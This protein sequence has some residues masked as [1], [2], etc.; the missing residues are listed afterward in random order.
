MICLRLLLFQI[1]IICNFS[2]FFFFLKK[3]WWRQ[4]CYK[5]AKDM[6]EFF[7]KPKQTIK[8]LQLPLTMSTEP[9][10]KWLLL[11][12]NPWNVGIG[13]WGEVGGWGLKEKKKATAQ[14]EGGNSREN[15]SWNHNESID[16]SH[17]S[18]GQSDR[19]KWKKNFFSY[20]K[21]TREIP[22]TKR[23]NRLKRKK[24]QLQSQTS[25]LK[26]QIRN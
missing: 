7:F 21:Q 20:K 2:K 12:A 15:K 3:I 18:C 8:M 14:R 9:E 24:N 25:N 1:Q 5:S 16:W 19:R 17:P 13:W 22:T 26:P 11:Q 10:E 23:A 6:K 4:G